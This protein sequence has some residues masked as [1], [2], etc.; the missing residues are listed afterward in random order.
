MKNSIMVTDSYGHVR[1][2]D[3]AEVIGVGSYASGDDTYALIERRNGNN[4]YAKDN[5]YDVLVRVKEALEVADADDLSLRMASIEDDV[6][7][8]NQVLAGVRAAAKAHAE[9]QA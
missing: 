8:I 4:V 9:G 5:W 2:I 6:R 7:I 1:N 3:P